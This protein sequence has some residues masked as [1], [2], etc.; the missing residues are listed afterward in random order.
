MTLH[1]QTKDIQKSIDKVESFSRE[2]LNPTLLGLT[3]IQINELKG[4]V[5]N[6]LPPLGGHLVVLRF[7]GWFQEIRLTVL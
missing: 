2:V 7:N 5:A 6:L 4:E 3:D 1:E